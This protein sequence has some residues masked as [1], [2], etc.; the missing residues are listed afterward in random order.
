MKKAVLV[1]AVAATLVPAPANAEVFPYGDLCDF[2]SIS[3][4]GPFGPE[5][6]YSGTMSGGPLVVVDWDDVVANPV[7]ATLTCDLQVGEAQD[8]PNA[9]SVSASGTTVVTVPPTPVPHHGA[10]DEGLLYECTSVTLT[11]AHGDTTTVYW[12][13]WNDDWTTD[14]GTDC[15]PAL[16]QPCCGPWFGDMVFHEVIDPAVCPI[17]DDVFPPEGDVG[18]IWDCPPYEF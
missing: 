8:A 2:L 7:S 13:R 15:W 12:D 4:A 16:G 1:A 11:D 10:P 6:T 17:L 9:F 5:G 3:G 14:P 18:L